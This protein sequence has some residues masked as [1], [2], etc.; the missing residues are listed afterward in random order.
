MSIISGFNKVKNYVKESEG[1]KL[2][3]RWTSS[4]TV[5]VNGKTL[6]DVVDEL[7]TASKKD[8]AS[9]GN[10]STSQVV[11][12]NDTRLTDARKASDVSAWAKASTKP[13][14]TASEIG[15]ATAKHTHDNAD[16]TSLD[17][18][19]ITSGTI[20]IDRLPQG[21]LDRLVRVADDTAR[22]KLTTNDV[23]LGDTVKV[24]STGKMYYVVDETKLS[25]EAGYEPY[26]ADSA[27][28]VPWSGVTGKPSTYTPSEH[29][30]T[31]SQITDFPTSMPASDVYSWAK[32]SGKPTYTKSEVGLGN[33]DNTADANKSVKYA[34]S[35]GSATTATKATGVVD[36]GSTNQTIQIGFGG[37]GI[38]G[39]NIKYIAGYT[40]GNGSDIN[41]KIKDISKGNLQSWLGLGSLAYSSATSLPANG[42]N[43]STVNGYTVN[44]NVPANA[45]FT[46]TWR[47]IQN[48]LTSTSTTD[49]LSA[50]QGKAL[51]D[52]I[53]TLN[54]NLSVIKSGSWKFT[55]GGIE[56]TLKLF[57]VGRVT[58]GTFTAIGSI[59]TGGVGVTLSDMPSKWYPSYDIFVSY[60]SI[61]SNT[62]YASNRLNFDTNGIF[63]LATGNSG[64]LEH[65]VSFC[66]INQGLI[67]TD[68]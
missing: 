23:Q 35:A 26:T 39:D 61:A 1:Y 38:S 3:S 11:M 28:S 53:T 47:G 24:K 57:S 13:S 9:S 5:D 7:G 12:G 33:V 37:D 4:D 14:Y 41:A 34:T 55:I 54:S 10:A 65:Y 66:Y 49:S 18:E 51:N 15:A 67:T 62:V 50:A 30:H 60:T 63:R 21:A 43:S 45:K 20:S 8:V 36:Y 44:S 48:N 6:T 56:G 58:F 27:T 42:G 40:S 19:K 59:P 32:A 22:F 31:K 25:S 52:K 2:L 64:Y 17:A 16:I 29:T 68:A 46:D